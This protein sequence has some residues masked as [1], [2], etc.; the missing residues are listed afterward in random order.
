[1]IKPGYFLKTAILAAFSAISLNLYC[2]TPGLPCKFG[3]LGNQLFLKEHP[4]DF[5]TPVECN[6]LMGI[7]H[8]VHLFKYP[9]LEKAIITPDSIYPSKIEIIGIDSICQ[10]YLFAPNFITYLDRDSNISNLYDV[11]LTIDSV[12]THLFLYSLESKINFTKQLKNGKVFQFS[13]T[14]KFKHSKCFLFYYEF[15]ATKSNDRAFTFGISNYT[16]TLKY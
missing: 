7:N 9:D 10:F 6:G 8:S 4:D 11:H 2:Q 3:L 12:D 1:M 15:Y 13:K 5:F 14:L 16:Y